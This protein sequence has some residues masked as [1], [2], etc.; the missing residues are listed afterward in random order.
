MDVSFLCGKILKDKINRSNKSTKI[1]GKNEKST[2][3]TV[4]TF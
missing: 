4:H 3:S 2:N 1:G